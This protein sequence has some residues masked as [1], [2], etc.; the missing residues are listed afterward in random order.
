MSKPSCCAPAFESTLADAN[1]LTHAFPNVMYVALAKMPQ[2]RGST[3][4][5]VRNWH[6][7]DT[8]T[9]HRRLA[10]IPA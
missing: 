2:P 4:Q 10:V 3:T 8:V 1:G 9:P 7:M 5:G 6:T